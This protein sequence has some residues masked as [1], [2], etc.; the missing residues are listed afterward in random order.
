MR[1]ALIALML[2]MGL[3]AGGAAQ[4]DAAS[5]RAEYIAQVDPICQSFVG[6]MGDAFSAY[7]RSFKALNHAAKSGNTKR[8]LRG[9]KRTAASLN[10]IAQTRTSMLDQIAPVQPVTSDVAT[11]NTWVGFLRQEAGF[12]NAAA[13]AILGLK[14]GKFFS[15]L[16]QADSAQ[17]NGKGAIA[18][19]GFQVCGTPPVV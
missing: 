5:T 15:N 14:I 1:R 12:E 17:S 8:F 3:I 4:A 9:T 13:T 2:S 7:Q 18:G 10:R 11:I 6:P 16:R 19:F